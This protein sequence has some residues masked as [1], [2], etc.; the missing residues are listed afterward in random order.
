MREINLDLPD[1]TGKAPRYTFLIYGPMGSGKTTLAASFPRPLFLSDVT[2]SGYESLRGLDESVLFE[3]NVRPRALGIEKMNDMAQAREMIAPLVASGQVQ[4]IVD[5]SLTFYADLYLNS[6]FDMQGANRDNRKAYGEL[7]IHLRD[8]RVKWQGFQCNIVWLCLV[9][10]PDD[11]RPQGGPM[12]P[13]AESGKF[14]AGCDYQLFMR[15]DRFKRGQEFVDNYEL[16]SRNWGKYAARVRRAVGVPELPSP[17]VNTTYSGILQAMGFDPEATRAAL[18]PY[19]PPKPFVI[20]A[21]APLAPPVQAPVASTVLPSTPR[22]AMAPHV[23]NVAR[24][25]ANNSVRP[26]PAA[27]SV[28]RRPATPVGRPNS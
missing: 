7:G 12:I 1:Q 3:P 11:D 18:P 20:A 13:G 17:L 8:L 6:I 19:L 26:Q 4:T 2:E 28:T 9:R 16:H 14:G 10:D 25:V 15:H 23:P 21:P 27:P 5:D 24:P 22:P